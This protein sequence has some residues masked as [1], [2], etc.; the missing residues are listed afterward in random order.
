M[1]LVVV[2]LLNEE[3]S[4]LFGCSVEYIENGISAIIVVQ[5]LVYLAESKR[6]R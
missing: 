3:L 5:F 6:L 2:F 1:L 4:V